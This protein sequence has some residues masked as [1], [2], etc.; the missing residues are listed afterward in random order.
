MALV[1]VL[2]TLTLTVQAQAAHSAVLTNQPSVLLLQANTLRATLAGHAAMWID[3]QANRVLSDV[4]Q[5]PFTTVTNFQSA[6]FT[7]AAYWFQLRVARTP[8]APT[9]WQLAMG[10]PYLD[11]IQIWIE[12]ERD[13]DR[14]KNQVNPLRLGDH[15]PLT[16]RPLKTRMPTVGLNLPD[17]QPRTVWIRVSSTSAVNFNATVWLPDA[18]MGHETRVNLYQGGYFGVLI[19]VMLIYGL[20]GTWL[21]DIGMLLYAIYVGTLVVLYLGINGY[22]QVIFPLASTF[23]WANDALVGGGVIG[24]LVVMPLLWDRL[25]NMGAQ[26]PLMHRIYKGISFG[27]ALLLPSVVTPYYRTV[28]ALVNKV[29]ILFALLCLGLVIL[30]LFRK[31][32]TTLVLYLLAFT[33]TIFGIIA[34]IAGVMGWIEPTPFITNAYQMASL[35]HIMVMNVGLAM[36]V[37]QIQRNEVL[38]EQRAG[39]AIE[40][41][42]EHKRFV[43]MLSHEF[44]NPL[45][46]IDRATNLLQ[47]KL[48][49]LANAD[50]A[51]LS[52]IRNNVTKLGILVDSFLIS[53]A[54]EEQ[55]LSPVPSEQAVAS[56]LASVVAAQGGDFQRYVA[57][58][59]TPPDLHF[60]FDARLIDIAVNN[61]LGNALRYTNGSHDTRLH[62]TT[63]DRITLSAQLDGH[64][65][66]ITVADQGPG[67]VE[68][69]LKRLGQPYYR[70]STSTGKQ[71]TG[72]GYYFSRLIVEAHGGKLSAANLTP[73][74]LL[75]TL[76]LP[77]IN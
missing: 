66:L 7:P 59:V 46:S 45:A 13:S 27:A 33:A 16:E 47:L 64:D 24:G 42:A 28:G 76:R 12:S 63:D 57:L 19:I 26:F 39:L 69:E 4:R 10:E 15:I 71:G 18:L 51:R 60:S 22:A 3:T 77:P 8:D 25:L 56:L 48:T 36:R 37:R 67:L 53:E 11:D 21:R 43:A 50:E 49:T 74:G 2:A 65:L 68:N 17:T 75:V 62:S 34:Q 52:G 70:A 1:I 30:A 55:R 40:R 73:R 9:S 38:A 6:G 23:P 32:S 41:T 20:L 29:S 72:L 54:A 5:Q 44:R 35:V 58:V 14:A 61:L 31:K